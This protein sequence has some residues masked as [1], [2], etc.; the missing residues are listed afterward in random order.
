[1]GDDNDLLS[2]LTED[3][4]FVSITAGRIELK[5]ISGDGKIT[6]LVFEQ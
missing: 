3:W 4:D 2:E 6:V 5:D 1:M